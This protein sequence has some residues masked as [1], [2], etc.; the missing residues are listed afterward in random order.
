M[1]ITPAMV[2]RLIISLLHVGDKAAGFESFMSYPLALKRQYF[3]KG[4]SSAGWLN[5]SNSRGSGMLLFFLKLPY[6]PHCLSMPGTLHYMHF[7]FWWLFKKYISLLEYN[8]L[9]YNWSIILYSLLEYSVVLVSAVQQ[10]E[11]AICTHISPYP[12]PLEHPSH[13]PYPTPLGHHKAPSWSPCALRQLPTSHLMAFLKE[14]QEE[15]QM[16]HP[17]LSGE[18]RGL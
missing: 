11:S 8:F 7:S 5:R 18:P 4:W 1:N 14:C 12:L 3:C 6:F 10:S 9:E 17:G 15:D 16:P 13:P 2:P